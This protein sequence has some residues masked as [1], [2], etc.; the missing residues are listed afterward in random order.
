MHLLRQHPYA[1]NPARSNSKGK[2]RP[3][4]KP[5]IAELSFDETG[6]RTN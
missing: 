1:V 6:T 4:A 2:P 5:S 3:R